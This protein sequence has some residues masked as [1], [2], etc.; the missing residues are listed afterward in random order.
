MHKIVGKTTVEDAK[1][2]VRYKLIRPTVD[3]VALLKV[4]LTDACG[5]QSNSFISEV[6]D[7]T[8]F[9]AR[10]MQMKCSD[11]AAFI[12][13]SQDIAHSLAH[14][15]TSRSMKSGNLLILDGIQTNTNTYFTIVIKAEYDNVMNTVEDGDDFQIQILQEVFL[16]KNQKLFKIGI[17]FEK[18]NIIPDFDAQDFDA[19]SYCSTIVFDENIKI[20]GPADYFYSGF[21]GFKL[22]SNEK[23][24]TERF[25][26]KS[27][28]FIKE[29]INDPEQRCE[30]V[31][32]L[33]S[34]LKNEQA[35]VMPNDYKNLFLPEG[36]RDLY[37][38]TIQAQF[39]HAFNKDN[40][41]LKGRL[42]NRKVTF[43]GGVYLYAPADNFEDH[44]KFIN[45]EEELVQLKLESQNTI[46]Q[47]FGKPYSNE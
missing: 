37:E 21:L 27:L 10:S 26:N 19:N 25:Y 6:E 36:L 47:I 28:E 20:S 9:F 22:D 7:K 35:G 13:V 23:I 42:K 44:V 3:V 11:D 1:A 38:T 32:K 5:K 34:F 33:V 29:N 30:A 4:R 2:E 8:K 41:L 39:P 40:E 31:N 17:L 15:Q 16:S 45:S 46:V 24:R 43:K 12:E 14:C 18:P